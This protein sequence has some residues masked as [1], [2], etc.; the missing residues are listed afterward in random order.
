MATIANIFA[1]I[2]FK[3]TFDLNKL[4]LVLENAVYNPAKFAGLVLK[5]TEPKS[6]F[7][8][9]RT[10]T[11]VATGIKSEKVLNDAVKLLYTKLRQTKLFK[12]LIFPRVEIT[13][14][15]ASYDYKKQLQLEQFYKRYSKLCIYEKELFPSLKFQL[16]FPKMTTLIFHTGKIILTGTRNYSNIQRALQKVL[17]LLSDFTITK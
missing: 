11:I 12:D 4:V 3:T 9:F 14:Y 5:F 6:S 15:T 7:L 16:E 17:F 10:G 1:K 2:V 13:N 8:I